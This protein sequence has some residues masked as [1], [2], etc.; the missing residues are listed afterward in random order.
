MRP[1]TVLAVTGL[2][3]ASLLLS[4]QATMNNAQIERNL[5]DA[6]KEIG[7]EHPDLKWTLSKDRKAIRGAYTQIDEISPSST[8]L[9]PDDSLTKVW[10]GLRTGDQRVPA[11]LNFGSS[12]FLHY[13]LAMQNAAGT[14]SD[15]DYLSVHAKLMQR[16]DSLAPGVLDQ[17]QKVVL[18]VLPELRKHYRDAGFSET[19]AN[20]AAIWT[21]RQA[22][23]GPKAVPQYKQLTTAD[24]L[25]RR[26]GRLVIV[27]DPLGAAVTVDGYPWQDPTRAS[28][29]IDAGTVKIVLSLTDYAT[30]TESFN[31]VADKKNE[32]TRPL[33][34]NP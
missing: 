13:G 11:K 21:W 23:T 5:G 29:F 32:F 1:L 30:L 20:D 7:L 15:A 24:L 16:Q 31:V 4:Q 22:R 27:S 3:A 12:E 33:K 19:D 34:K 10:R 26:K 6:S 25:S 28:E 9:S 2:V 8:I 14:L 18:A 17:D